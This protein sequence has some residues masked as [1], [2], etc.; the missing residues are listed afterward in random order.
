MKRICLI[1]FLAMLLL[2]AC[3]SSTDVDAT[4]EELA[5]LREKYPYIN[6]NMGF[7]SLDHVPEGE[8]ASPAQI[9]FIAEV[10]GNYTYNS[11]TT[12]PGTADYQGPMISIGT[13]YIPIKIT[14]VI[15]TN[16]EYKLTDTAAYMSIPEMVF[17]PDDNFDEGSQFVVLGFDWGEYKGKTQFSISQY[18]TFYLTDDNHVLSM[19][20]Y[21][22]IDAYSGRTLNNFISDMDHVME[23]SGW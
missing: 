13:Y 15:G 9:L 3:S 18:T 8:W 17:S 20:D 16:Q 23:K 22:M 21:P 19:T 10:T 12:N 7:S 1:I 14:E 5:N 2:C 11:V 4:E 6:N